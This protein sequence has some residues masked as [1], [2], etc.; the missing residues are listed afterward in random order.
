MGDYIMAKPNIHKSN[1]LLLFI[2][3]APLLAALGCVEKEGPVGEAPKP[4]QSAPAAPAAPAMKIKAV[5]TDKAALNGREVI[6]QGKAKPGVAIEF[7][8]EQPY[9]LKD[10]T[11]E[12]W[13]VTTGIMPKEGA[14]ITVKGTVASPYRIKGRSFDVV[15]IEAERIK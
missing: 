2:I 4:V 12:I 1:A 3:V 15:V 11:D 6:V 10:E 14:D 5:L 9:Q 13:I 7:V 8:D